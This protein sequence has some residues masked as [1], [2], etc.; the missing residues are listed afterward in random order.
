MACLVSG[1]FNVVVLRKGYKPRLSYAVAGRAAGLSPR[2]RVIRILVR[3]ARRADI[4]PAPN[5]SVGAECSTERGGQIAGSAARDGSGLSH[6]EG[7]LQPAWNRA[8]GKAGRGSG[9]A[10]AAAGRAGGPV[11]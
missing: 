8:T 7:R 10:P 5:R 6:R 2:N 11:A 1:E 9:V 4:E 3:M